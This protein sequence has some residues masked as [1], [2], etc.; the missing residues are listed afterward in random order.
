MSDA[1]KSVGISR[2]AGEPKSLLIAFN[3]SPTNDEMRAVHEFLRR[4]PSVCPFC[5][6]PT[7]SLPCSSCGEPDIP[8]GF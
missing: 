5:T 7:Y 8:E 4:D 2:D 1:L 3:R 6:K